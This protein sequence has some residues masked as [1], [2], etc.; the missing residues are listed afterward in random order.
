MRIFFSLVYVGLSIGLIVYNLAV[1]E[2]NNKDAYEY[3]LEGGG[4]QC[5]DS[6]ILLIQLG[7]L[8]L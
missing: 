5:I 6:V 3:V 7:V 2:Y 1:R 4:G 8:R